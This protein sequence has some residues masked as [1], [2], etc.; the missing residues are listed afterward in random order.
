MSILNHSLVLVQFKDMYSNDIGPV[1]ELPLTSSV[2]DLQVIVQNFLKSD[3]YNNLAFFLEEKRILSSVL[4]IFDD[5]RDFTSREHKL[6]LRCIPTDKFSE[7][8]SYQHFNSLSGHS[9]VI[10]KVCFHPLNLFVAS[11]S[12][13]A[14]IYIWDINT[15]TPYSICKGHTSWILDLK[16][17]STGNFLI[18]SSMDCSIILWEPMKKSIP[19]SKFQG[20]SKWISCLSWDPLSSESKFVSASKDT[21]LKIWMRTQSI[22]YLTLSGHENAITSVIWAKNSYIY[23]ASKDRTLIVWDGSS[24]KMLHKFKDHSHWINCLDVYVSGSSSFLISGSEDNTIFWY[25]ISENDIKKSRLT[26]HQGP[27]SVISFSPCG[28]YF[29]SGSFDKSVK[30][31]SRVEGKYIHT[32]RGHLSAIYQ[33]VWSKDSRFIASVGKD[34]SVRIWDVIYRKTHTILTGHIDEIYAIDWCYNLKT[35]IICSGGKDKLIRLHKS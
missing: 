23:S 1:V 15:G 10:T 35:N 29:A 12:G 4:E 34:K 28:N 32:F 22:C 6:I 31:W 19:I 13:D 27:I 7:S 5:K 33:L 3:L 25:H 21:T 18:S 16:W 20:H 2:S 8:F 26:G 11:G 14:N 30:I 24:G 17:S 9:D